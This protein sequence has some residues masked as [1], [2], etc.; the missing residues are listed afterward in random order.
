[1]AGA[2]GIDGFPGLSRGKWCQHR[3]PASTCVDGDVV[4]IVGPDFDA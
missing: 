3:E 4:F 2:G 1:M